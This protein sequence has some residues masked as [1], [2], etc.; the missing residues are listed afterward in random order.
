MTTTTQMVFIISIMLAMNIG[1]AMFQG[2]ITE[3]NPSGA[4]FFN[5]SSSPYANYIK[6]DTLVVDDA[7]LPADEDAESDDSGNVFTD[8]YQGI[9]SWTQ[10]T[11]A[12]FKFIGNIMKQPAGFLSDINIPSSIALAIGVLW[13]LLALLIVV[14]WWM[15]R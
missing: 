3:S 1:L 8:T 4:Q 15:G 5:V 9:K 12:P 2:A 10:K 11:L 13:Y 6:N 14:S 7:Y